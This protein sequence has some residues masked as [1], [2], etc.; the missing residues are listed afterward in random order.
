MSFTLASHVAIFIAMFI[1]P[2]SA[3]A[4]TLGTTAGF[5]LA[6]FPIVVVFR[7]GSHIVYAIV[8]ALYL[9]KHPDLLDAKWR[10]ITFS[11]VIA[12]IHAIAEVA[13]VVPFYFG[14]ML[15]EGFYARGFVVGIILL[16]GV[17]TIVHSMV[18]ILIA[19]MI[20]EP[21]KRLGR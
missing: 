19:R 14:G 21:L 8:G 17:G 1:S 4:V 6:G 5:L 15:A 7:A 16:V 2:K 20:W 12:I 3:I 9:K 10:F 13:A 18:D 11:F